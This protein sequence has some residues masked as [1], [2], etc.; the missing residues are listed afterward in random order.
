MYMSII[1]INIAIKAS[2]ISTIRTAATAGPLNPP[3]K[4]K[5]LSIAICKFSFTSSFKTTILNCTS[6]Y[7][8]NSICIKICMHGDGVVI[9][10]K[11]LECCQVP[12]HKHTEDSL[13]RFTVH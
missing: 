1:N 3:V 11:Y 2:I 12:I 13:N 5:L 7:L 4:V 10:I 8:A 6:F 9:V